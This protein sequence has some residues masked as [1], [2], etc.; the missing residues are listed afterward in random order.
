MLVQ[1]L[2]VRVRGE[3][4]ILEVERRPKREWVACGEYMGEY[5]EAKGNVPRSAAER[6][7]EWAKVKGVGNA[8]R[9]SQRTRRYG[10]DLI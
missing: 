4:C 5:Y 7:R 10:T 9:W 3:L 1:Y 8:P 6:W 2:P